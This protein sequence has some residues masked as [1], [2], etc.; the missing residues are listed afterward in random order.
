MTKF[1]P[2]PWTQNHDEQHYIADADFYIGS[3]DDGRFREIA[4][5][6]E[7]D[8]GRDEGKANAR[9]IVQAPEMFWF[10]Q[11][12]FNGI[13]AGMISI[14]SP[15]DETLANVISR[16]RAVV[17]KVEVAGEH[18]QQDRPEVTDTRWAV[19]VLL[20][21]IAAKFEANPTFDLWRSDA[22]A[23]VR[24]FKHDLSKAPEPSASVERDA[25]RR[26]LELVAGHKGKTIYSHDPEYRQGA[27]DAYEQ[28]ADIAL[29]AL[30]TPPLTSEDGA[31]S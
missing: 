9:L 2:G 22:A 11:Q 23:L 10:I 16:G 7:F 15:A 17:S 31:R 28:L 4:Q 6:S 13:D 21:T 20:E 18:R 8:F 26:A 3:V 5:I 29:A 1:T 12:I 25:F 27:H 19:N 14:S 24:S 30:S